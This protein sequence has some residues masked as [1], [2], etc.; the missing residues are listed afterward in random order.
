M[1]SLLGMRQFA[2][3]MD[4]VR[5]SSMEKRVVPATLDGKEN[6]VISQIHISAMGWHIMILLFVVENQVAMPVHLIRLVLE[7][8]ACSVQQNGQFS[9]V[10]VSIQSVLVLIHQFSVFVVEKVHVL[11]QIAVNAILHWRLV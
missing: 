9:Q 10:D 6:S 3:A 2:V 4:N 7:G 1:V 11:V 8:Y 5:F